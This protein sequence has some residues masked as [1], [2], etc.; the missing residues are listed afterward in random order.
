[1]I[2]LTKVENMS[3]KKRALVHEFVGK[4]K[5][6]PERALKIVENDIVNGVC[7]GMVSDLAE[8]CSFM[9]EAG[10]AEDANSP[11]VSPNVASAQELVVFTLTT[12]LLDLI[13]PQMLIEAVTEAINSSGENFRAE[14]VSLGEH[15]NH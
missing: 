7:K 2:K 10:I 14:L 15:T 8:V 3:Q 11:G 13:S 4:L 6:N 5:E 1:M 9:A 12:V